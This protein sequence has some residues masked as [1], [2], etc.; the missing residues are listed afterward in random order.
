MHLLLAGLLL[1]A[2]AG[3]EIPTLAQPVVDRAGVLS[4][5]QAAQALQLV[6]AL[7]ASDS[8]QVA[9]LV[10]PT[11][12]GRAIE[13][14]AID[15]ARKCSLGQS[16]KNNG[17]LVVV[18][19]QDRKCRIEIG[20]GLEARLTDL[21]ASRIIRDEMIPHFKKGRYGDG[22]LAGLAAVVGAVK[23]E[24]RG[25]PASKVS[26]NVI[27]PLVLIAIVILLSVFSPRRRRGWGGAGW[28]LMS[29]MGGG[30]SSGGGGGGGGGW[31]GGGG[32]FGGGGAS[33]SW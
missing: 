10:V 1:A 28:I 18:A 33:G 23:G 8:T 14:Y 4:R 22:A 29:G 11:T 20:T 16:G 32:S 31:S 30:R 26:S 6:R 27:K 19:V 17:V 21:L 7:E 24:Y 25:K 3:Q 2:A 9:L 15:V 13:E 12:D 5:A